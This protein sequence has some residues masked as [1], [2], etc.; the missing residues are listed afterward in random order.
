MKQ[1]YV[2]S[3]FCILATDKDIESSKRAVCLNQSH[4]CPTGGVLQCRSSLLAAKD[5]CRSVL[6]GEKMPIATLGQMGHR[7]VPKESNSVTKM[8][9]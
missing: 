2:R 8:G 7:S 5:S 1:I 6:L 9:R 4:I 3:R